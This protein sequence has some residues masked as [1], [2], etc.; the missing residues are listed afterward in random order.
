MSKNYAVIMAGGIGS[1]FW[2]KSRT[3][4][5]KQFIDILGIGKT[6]IQLTFDRLALVVPAENIYII[7]NESYYGLVKEQIPNIKDDNILLE[8]ARRNTAPCIAYSCSKILHNEP[9]ANILI[10]PS[11]H[12]IHDE[13]KFKDYVKKAFR[14]LKLNPKA[15]LTLGIKPSRPDVNYGYIQYHEDKV[16]EGFHKVKTFTEKP[17]EELAKTF[18]KSGDFLWNSGIFLWKAKTIMNAFTKLL[19]D[20]YDAFRDGKNYYYRKGESAFIKKAYTLCTNISIDYG[21]LEK[22]KS[23]YVMPSSFGWTDLGTWGS[24]YDHYEKDYLGNAV[25]GKNVIIYDAA[26]CMVMNSQDKLMV[27]QGL[28]DYCVIDTAD[29][30][31]ILKK[32]EESTLK[33]IM[34][35]IKMKK[36]ERFL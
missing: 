6:L 36:G 16:E 34:A 28:N 24:L 29:V 30:L 3:A 8:P 33:K 7:T 21:V 17:N 19:P 25:S 15:L 26:N 5:P 4:Y 27:L 1:R 22:S 32:D 13:I 12:F 2:P 20:I 31:I 11:D 9:D 35:D 14:Y 23:V 10:A 18:L